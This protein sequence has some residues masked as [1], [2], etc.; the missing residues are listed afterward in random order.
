MKQLLFSST[1]VI[2][3]VAACNSN[4]YRS[5]SLTGMTG[6]STGMHS[7]VAH[8]TMDTTSVMVQPVHLTPK[9]EQVLGVVYA[10][11][12]RERLTRTLR[13]V[14]R[15]EVPE[16]A[17]ADVTSKIE[18]YVERL[19]V[20]FT[21]ESVRK[22]QPLLE[23]YSPMLVAAQEELLVARRLALLADTS[24]H[25][26]W[27]TARAN[28]EA[29]RQ[30]LAYWDITPE[31][32]AR[33][34]HT[35][36]ISKTLT[37]VSPVTGIVMEKNVVEGQQ[38]IPGM[39]LYRIADLST[40]WV[41]GDIYEQDMQFLR[42]GS[43]VRIEVVAYP[44]KRYKG[45]VSFIYPTLDR[46]SRTN[47]VRVTVP[48]PDLELKPGMYATLY[49]DQVLSPDAVTVPADAVVMTGKRA[50]VF[51]RAAPGMLVPREVVI[52]ARAG[53]RV[54]VLHGL[55]GGE[56]VVA[57]GNFLVDAESRLAGSTG[58]MPGM[59]HGNKRTSPQSDSAQTIDE[60]RHD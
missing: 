27:Q 17:I 4:Q 26:M 46:R 42:V 3:L 7:G 28:L 24:T 52:G 12:Q 51:V 44:G 13:T 14:G 23:V 1:V 20:S 48:N 30:R 10:V 60:H 5:S 21:G 40:V 2:L 33:I 8:G 18:G 41:E 31:Q 25:E 55:A 11:V 59:Q 39:R 50:L 22:G 15:I 37:M 45:R 56:V 49:I 29:A 16:P 53:D 38:I 36:K 47:R 57:A 54:Q 35:G 19:L 34:E 58:A 6:D 43:L 9:Q 32:I